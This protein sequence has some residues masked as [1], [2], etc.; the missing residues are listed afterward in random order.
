MSEDYE[1]FHEI[2]PF[3][4]KVDPSTLLNNEDYPW[5]QRNK[6]MTQAKKS[7]GFLHNYYDDTI[8]NFQPFLTSSVST[9]SSLVSFAYCTVTM[10]ILHR[11]TRCLGQP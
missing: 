8:A 4:V 9:F 1:K 5:L 2:P 11:L 6:E 10:D 3:K 7:E